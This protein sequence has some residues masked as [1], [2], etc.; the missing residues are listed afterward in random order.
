MQTENVHDSTESK[1]SRSGSF[2]FVKHFTC[3]ITN[4]FSLSTEPDPATAT[5]HPSKKSTCSHQ[6]LPQFCLHTELE[7]IRVNFLQWKFSSSH[8]VTCHSGSD[9]QHSQRPKVRITFFKTKNIL[10][11]SRDLAYKSS[12]WNLRTVTHR[13]TTASFFKNVETNRLDTPETC[14]KSVLPAGKMAKL[15]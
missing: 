3:Q 9:S 12:T 11:I 8:T 13:T 7:T 14:T 2:R 6:I 10:G 15:S 1:R 4:R 5:P